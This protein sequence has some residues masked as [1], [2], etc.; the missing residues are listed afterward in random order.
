M[1]KPPFLLG[2]RRN[3][4]TSLPIVSGRSTC[5]RG[6]IFSFRFAVPGE[7][8]GLTLI[9]RFSDRCRNPAM[10]SPATG[11]GIV[12]SRARQR[13]IGSARLQIPAAARKTSLYLAPTI[14]RRAYCV[15]RNQVLIIRLS[16][17]IILHPAERAEVQGVSPQGPSVSQRERCVSRKAETCSGARPT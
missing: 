16:L 13:L 8:F 4:R 2:V 7:S 14:H 10:P 6:S 5:I 1:N 3:N 9:L 15:S 12:R 11:S 17:S